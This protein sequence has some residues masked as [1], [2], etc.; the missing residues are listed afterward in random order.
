M[1]YT[2]EDKMKTYLFMDQ[3]SVQKLTIQ[4]LMGL[5]DI[6]NLGY[7]HCDLKP[8]NLMFTEKDGRI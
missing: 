2:L 7:V 3:V 1:D 6:H 5:R 8:A 4:I